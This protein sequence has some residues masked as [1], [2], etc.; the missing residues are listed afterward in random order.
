M[1][2]IDDPF[3]V[4]VIIGKGVMVNQ[5]GKSMS[6]QGIEELLL[7]LNQR[8]WTSVVPLSGLDKRLVVK[9]AYGI[10]FPQR[11]LDRKVSPKV[12]ERYRYAR[13][14][15]SKR[16]ED[17]LSIYQMVKKSSP[18]L[19]F[20]FEHR[21]DLFQEKREEPL[22]QTEL[23]ER[24]HQLIEEM[25][26]RL[27]HVA[28][29]ASHLLAMHA[30]VL[31]VGDYRFRLASN[32]VNRISQN[33]MNWEV[34]FWA[35]LKECL[36]RMDLNEHDIKQCIC[37]IDVSTCFVVE[38]FRYCDDLLDEKPIV[39]PLTV[40]RIDRYNARQR[41][42]QSSKATAKCPLL[43]GGLGKYSDAYVYGMWLLYFVPTVFGLVLFIKHALTNL[44]NEST[45]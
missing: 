38:L 45:R 13:F 25:Q 18:L 21:F 39:P 31:F 27:F 26:Q 40:S 29:H 24:L 11:L 36:Q 44:L 23:D 16:I 37:E 15:I 6:S 43:G 19:S 22:K 33:K 5:N 4:R 10:R 12:E 14:I 32:Q 8:V 2:C 35:Q 9:E 28:Q 17:L 1:N 3:D 41:M 34:R 20:L 30:I 7:K 42:L